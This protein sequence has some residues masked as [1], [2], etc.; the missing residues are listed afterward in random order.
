[1]VVF[2]GHPFPDLPLKRG[3]IDLLV[4]PSI[5]YKVPIDSVRIKSD[6]IYRHWQSKHF[7]SIYVQPLLRKWN[8]KRELV[9][10]V[11]FLKSMG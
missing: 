7:D 11:S 2:S 10:L 6:N 3:S 5:C 9:V 4:A 8:G 1:M